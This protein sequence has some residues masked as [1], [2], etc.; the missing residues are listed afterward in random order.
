[1]KMKFNS[2]S[3]F[4]TFPIYTLMLQS[5]IGLS[6]FGL[7]PKVVFYHGKVFSPAEWNFLDGTKLVK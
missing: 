2:V 5:Q 1:M 4:S 7:T 3:S 6:H